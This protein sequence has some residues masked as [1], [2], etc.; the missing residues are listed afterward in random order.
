MQEVSVGYSRRKRERWIHSIWAAS[1]T[2]GPIARTVLE[3]ETKCYYG[4]SSKPK[5]MQT[6]GSHAEV[7]PPLYGLSFSLFSSHSAE[8]RGF[9]FRSIITIKPFR[10]LLKEVS[11][12]SMIREWKLIRIFGFKMGWVLRDGMGRRCAGKTSGTRG[13]S[14]MVC[15]SRLG[16][17][18]MMEI[19]RE[20]S[21]HSTQ[22]SLAR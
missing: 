17:W 10:N 9:N 12:N 5:C 2:P 19:D 4:K 1:P 11:L 6:E 16:E 8:V 18:G 7:L 22:M 13:K 20:Y 21:S 15:I 14:T 3:K